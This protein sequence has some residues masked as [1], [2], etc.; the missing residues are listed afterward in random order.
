VVSE[1]ILRQL[2]MER[3][4]VL[5]GN[6]MVRLPGPD[7]DQIPRVAV[8]RHRSG[9]T[10]LFG[11]AV[12]ALDRVRLAHIGEATVFTGRAA[13]EAVIGQTVRSEYRTRF[14][15]YDGERPVAWAF[16]SREG[17]R[18]AELAVETLPEYRRRGYARRVASA[19]AVAKLA[20]GKTC[21]Y[22]YLADN[23][24]S[25]MLARSLGVEWQFDLATYS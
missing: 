20:D 19:W 14:A 2:A 18:A 6:V 24:P 15:I 25:E 7:P 21:F 11:E 5:A 4:G 13:V 3:I 12:A 17:S 9:W 10:L 22:S 1:V 8:Y 16:S 23:Y